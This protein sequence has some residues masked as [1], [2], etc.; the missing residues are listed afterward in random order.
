MSLCN[1]AVFLA[2]CISLSFY[3]L[4]AFFRARKITTFPSP[5][6]ICDKESKPMHP[7]NARDIGVF[8]LICFTVSG[9]HA[10]L[11]F[12]VSLSLP[13]TSLEE[14]FQEIEKKYPIR[15]YLA[16]SEL[17]AKRFDIKV[18]KQSILTLLKDLL[19]D[20]PL[21]YTFYRDYAIIIAQ[22]EKIAQLYSADYYKAL[23]LSMG[24]T[25]D[26]NDAVVGLRIGDI[27]N[28]G[29]EGKA[30][31]RGKILDEDGITG[32]PGVR[33]V[34]P[35]LEIGT[36]TD[37]G[38]NYELELPPGEHELLVSYLGYEELKKTFSIFSDGKLDLDLLKQAIS[39]EEVR[40]EAER[41]D[42]N[43]NETQ[44][45]ITRMDIKTIEKLP[46][47]MGEVDV[48]KS[49]LLQPGVS[50]IGE[51]AVG[52][53]VRGGESDQNLVIQDEAFIFNP[54]H[55]FG[56][57]STFNTDLV[58]TVTLY[59]G[60]IPAQYG[61]RLAS[62]L[63]VEMRDGNMERTY[64][65]GGI[66]VVASRASLEV[67]VVKGKSSILAGLRANYSDWVLNYIDVPEVRQSSTFFYD[68]NLRYTHRLS[69][70]N[71]L[72]IA[73][74]ASQ[75]DFQFAN[76]FGFDYSTLTAQG[77][78]NTIF[79]DNISSRLSVI[80]SRYNSAQSDL[81]G[82]LAST[83][84][85]KVNYIKFKE[86]VTYSPSQRLKI[87]LGGSSILYR[88][89][90]G[91]LEPLGEN[92]IISP[93]RVD[94][95]NAVEY[96]AFLQSDWTL[97]NFLAFSAGFRYALYSFLTNPKTYFSPEP[98]FS[99]RY[100]LNEQN[101]LKI[102]YSRTAQFINQ[103][104]NTD[105]PTPT[106]LW[107]LSSDGI[108]PQRS[109]NFSMGLF[110]NFSDN[111]WETS[112]EG[113]Y[114][115]IDEL[116]DYRDFAELRANDRLAEEL[117]RG[118]GR[119]YGVEFMIRKKAG[120]FNGWLSYTYSRT[121]RLVEGINEGAWYPSNIDRPHDLSLI[122]TL[123]FTQRHG[124]TVNF[125]YS[126]GRPT[127]IPTGSY[128]LTNALI[129]P[130]YS[131]RNQFRIPA[132]HRLD[133]AYTIGRGYVKDRRFKTSWT[134][135]VYNLYSRRNAFSVFIT[136]NPREAPRVNRFAILGNAFPSITFNIE[137]R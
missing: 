10:Q 116:F 6:T 61:G 1:R 120:K 60:N 95:E 71:T 43:V 119:A 35:G 85:N 58:K 100:K 73:G 20:T 132:Y 83:L 9:L 70:K 77:F 94:E 52:F 87:E 113:F 56:F 92:S 47:F 46:A 122:S 105:T 127:T 44:I 86:Q 17:P 68:L 65:K 84:R 96:A 11:N 106:S 79:T 72:T 40:I 88:V 81:S 28:L 97:N 63:D 45:G 62:V 48:V 36:T 19:S 123:Q 107:Q 133:V 118:Q 108:T 16:A 80:Y 57:F 137:T 24:N 64:F 109:H 23:E 26:G 78:L 99:L 5:H 37:A 22:R 12:E 32:L 50:T 25:R 42:A 31:L 8:L 30:V 13:Q 34:V 104:S 115:N 53:N 112:L 15:F 131:L 14:V 136:Q 21:G 49:L 98:R 76:D 67:P 114:R 89:L 7:R 51:G 125:N 59:K 90:P 74:Y 27:Q 102:G 4:P 2:D 135:S 18:E 33:L 101:S 111:N 29:P 69:P 38:G 117:L 129:V 3:V 39:L 82:T 110:R 93:R 124:L 121:E 130:D 103:I 134:L 55:A 54:S 126:S 91:E 75:D 41:A 128:A 66:G